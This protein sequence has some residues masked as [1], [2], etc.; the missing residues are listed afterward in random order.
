MQ[1]SIVILGKKSFSYV[2]QKATSSKEPKIC[3]RGDSFDV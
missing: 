3:G 2:V 1:T